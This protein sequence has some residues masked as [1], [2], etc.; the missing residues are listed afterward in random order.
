MFGEVCRLRLP[1]NGIIDDFQRSISFFP[2]RQVPSVEHSTVDT[3]PSSPIVRTNTGVNR[4]SLL[5]V[6]L[7]AKGLSRAVRL[8]GAPE[9]V[10]LPASVSNHDIC[11]LRATPSL[12]EIATVRPVRMKWI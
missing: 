10:I 9:H 6:S 4:S 12:S 2:V 1:F 3:A 11:E 5:V 8:D 7:P